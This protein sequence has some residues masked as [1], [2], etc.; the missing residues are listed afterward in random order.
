[1]YVYYINLMSDNPFRGV[2]RDRR[3]KRFLRKY[4]VHGAE[5]DH[6]SGVR[7]RT[8]VRRTTAFSHAIRLR[9]RS[10]IA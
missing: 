4:P 1:M 6:E 2:S 8:P 5:D 10:I 9:D 3:R 7:L